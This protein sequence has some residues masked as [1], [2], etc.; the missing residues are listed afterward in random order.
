MSA[1]SLLAK[2]F[3]CV[4]RADVV[5]ASVVSNGLMIRSDTAAKLAAGA[6]PVQQLA[7]NVLDTGGAIG[8]TLI[9][10]KF[11]IRMP[12]KF[13]FSGQ[14]RGSAKWALVAAGPAGA[15]GSLRMDVQRNGAAISGVTPYDCPTRATDAG[16][17]YPE[18]W[19]VVNV[20]AATAFAAGDTLDV[21]FSLRNQAVIVGNTLQFGLN[22]D[23]ATGGNELVV[24]I[25][26][27][28]A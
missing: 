13:I 10:H 3:Y 6:T 4:G 11:S 1:V 28:A 2:P 7:S 12:E 19:M 18:R 16:G 15:R 5:A 23:P 9:A 17:P 22:C 20:P 14:I 24:E 21:I 26:V 25:D 8:S 27:G